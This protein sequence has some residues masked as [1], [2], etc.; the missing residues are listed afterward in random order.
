MKSDAGG[1]DQAG[2]SSE[3]SDSKT[4]NLE[5]SCGQSED[6][7]EELYILP[8]CAPAPAPTAASKG[9]AV[10]PT[11]LIPAATS[12]GRAASLAPLSTA[13]VSGGRTTPATVVPVSEGSGPA[14][15]EGSGVS[16]SPSVGRE[17]SDRV[18]NED[19]QESPVPSTRGTET[20][21]A[22]LPPVLGGSE[23]ATLKWAAKGP[24]GTV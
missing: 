15:F 24:V 7:D 22:I 13:D 19:V 14:E 2:V 5:A 16:S 1:K 10:Q 3:G 6:E 8:Q 4:V 23:A 21:E 20:S 11:S 18:L 9:R 12:E 17:G